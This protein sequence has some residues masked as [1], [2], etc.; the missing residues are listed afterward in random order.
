MS[1]SERPAFDGEQS[2]ALAITRALQAEQQAEIEVEESRREAE[3]LL[4]AS[5]NEA[6]EIS[7]KS[8][9]RIS[10][11]FQRC[12]QVSSYGKISIDNSDDSQ[13]GLT[14]KSSAQEQSLARAVEKVAKELTVTG[15]D[16]SVLT[17][18]L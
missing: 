7:E 5:R 12:A 13:N 10:T 2:M 3:Q 6:R 9:L 14:E 17:D 11:F 4:L 8:D 16:D 18:G 1:E 15:R